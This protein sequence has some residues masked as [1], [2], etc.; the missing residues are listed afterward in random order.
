MHNNLIQ[1]RGESCGAFVPELSTLDRAGKRR[2][3]RF[4][5]VT[6]SLNFFVRITHSNGHT[7]EA[8]ER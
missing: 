2:P 6:V 4:D 8:V 7:I 5:P 1:G 3:Y